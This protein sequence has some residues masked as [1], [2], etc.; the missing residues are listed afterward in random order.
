MLKLLFLLC[1]LL[2]LQG[3]IV[4]TAVG[5]ITETI[6]AGVEVTGAV[7]GTAV[8]IVVPDAPCPLKTNV[9]KREIFNN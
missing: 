4:S 2:F 7:V 9:V 8:D 6:E 5:F 3:C 1:S